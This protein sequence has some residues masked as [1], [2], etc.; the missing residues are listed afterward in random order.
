MSRTTKNKSCIQF[1]EDDHCVSI[2]NGRSQHVG[3]ITNISDKPSSIT[4]TDVSKVLKS[5]KIRRTRWQKTDWGW[6][7]HIL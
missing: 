4:L 7:C 1:Y 3:D 5:L 6:E 2:F